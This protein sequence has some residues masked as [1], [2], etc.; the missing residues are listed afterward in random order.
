[1]KGKDQEAL[2]PPVEGADNGI[3]SLD[4][5]VSQRHLRSSAQLDWPLLAKKPFKRVVRGDCLRHHG[6]LPVADN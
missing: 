2:G 5:S 3:A 1:M 6:A 4:V